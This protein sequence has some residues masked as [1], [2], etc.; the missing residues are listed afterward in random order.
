MLFAFFTVLAFTLRMK[1]IWDKTADALSQVKAVAPNCI[2]SYWIF[3]KI[4]T[5]HTKK[6]VFLKNVTVEAVGIP[7]LITSWPL[8]TFSNILWWNRKYTFF[9]NYHLYDCIVSWT[10][11]SFNRTSFLLKRMTNRHT[12]VIH[13]WMI[14][15][16]IYKVSKM[17]LPFKTIWHCENCSLEN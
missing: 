6:W 4:I 5:T 15:R 1:T 16:H 12:M 7:D 10:N 8:S 9:E 2:S 17:S 14:D 11:C 13:T 3:K